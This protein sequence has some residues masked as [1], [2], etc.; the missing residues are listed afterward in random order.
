MRHL[1]LTLALLAGPTLADC[2]PA[3]DRSAELAALFDATR[4][5]PSE[6]AARPHANAMWEIWTDAPDEPA[7]ALLDRGMS[8]IRVADYLGA[9]DALDRLVAYC[10]DYAEGWNQRAFVHFLT[11]DYDAALPDLRRTV[12]IEPN[13]VGA[14]SGIA[15][16]LTALGREDE[17][18]ARL[19]EALALNPWI[20]ERHLLK[21]PAG[22]DL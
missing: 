18:Q 22:T 19:R 7:Q 15:L 12:E 1:V 10:P 16:T 13:H 8:A 9:L 2:P 3:P 17:A 5:A 14:L 11:G 6:T 21:P 4:A 20:A